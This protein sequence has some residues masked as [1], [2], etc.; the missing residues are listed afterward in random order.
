MF[1]RRLKVLL[2]LLALFT[3]VLLLRAAQVQVLQHDEWSQQAA[4]SMK[5]SQLIDTVRGRILD[6]HGRVIAVDKP[7]VDVVVHYK[8][9]TDPPDDK[10]LAAEADR[11]LK[12]RQGEEYTRLPRSRRKELIAEEAVAVKQRLAEMWGELST[13]ANRTSEDLAEVRKAIVNRVEM[14]KRI[15]WR[16]N[17]ER[18]MQDR[19]QRQETEAFWRRWL[20]EGI[21]GEQTDPERYVITVSEEAEAHVVLRAVSIEVQNHLGKHADRF[22]GLALRASTHRTYPFGHAGCHLMGRVTRV[23]REDL[24]DER[25][26]KE[27]TRQYLHNDMIGRGGLESLL[28]PALR[29]ARGKVERVPGQDKELSRVN[30]IPGQDVRTTID[31]ELQ[32]RVE[33]A[34]ASAEL[35]GANDEV[36]T[37]EFHG[38]AVVIDIASGEVLALASYPTFDLNQFDELYDKLLADDVNHPLLNR[39]TQS[40]LQPGSTIKPFVGLAAITQGVPIGSSPLTADAGIECSGF[41]VLR[42]RQIKHGRCWTESKFGEELRSKGMTAAHHPIPSGA[43]HPTGWLTFADAL[44]RSC[45]VYFETLADVM[46]M[47]GL[48]TWYERFGLGRPTGL[49]IPEARGRLPRSYVGPASDRRSKTWFS[50][51]GQDPVS[52]TPIQMANAAATAARGGIWYRP[53]L[54]PLA[55]SEQLKLRLPELRP[56]PPAV[57]PS[58]DDMPEVPVVPPPPQPNWPEAYSLNLSPAAVAAMRDGMMKVVTSRAGTGTGLMRRAPGLEGIRICGKTGTAQAPRFAIPRRD[59]QTRQVLRDPKG[60]AIYDFPIPNSPQSPNPQLPWY[61]GGGKTGTELAHAWYIGFA[62]ADKPTVAFAVMVEYGGSGGL[63]AAAVARQ[64][65]T[66]CVDLGYLPGPAGPPGVRPLDTPERA[67]AELLRNA[68]GQ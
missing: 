26:P 17:Y 1:E 47:E 57:D 2:G 49:G 39:A 9:L 28:E 38:G 4:E 42:G 48:S 60:R 51:I 37:A 53:R 31:I 45:N 16:K 43:P 68:G 12:A 5:R 65:L 54:V 22:P 29:G 40:Q 21:A 63:A 27:E 67:S 35:V 62:P 64:T 24:L 44:E 30:P 46:G 50:G 34:F 19:E 13:L 36:E 55:T 11:R 58:D 66:A 7:C 33:A 14:R 15:A 6:R 56:A 10:W 32:A 3:L 20:V 52:A 18:A 41:L 61:R 8:A 59:P 23:N 25:N